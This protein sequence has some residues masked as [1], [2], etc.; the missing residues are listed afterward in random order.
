M[1]EEKRG[2]GWDGMR[3]PHTCLEGL[4]AYS[5]PACLPADLQA[6]GQNGDFRQYLSV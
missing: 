5:Q 4:I 6:V 2:V 1:G 3:C